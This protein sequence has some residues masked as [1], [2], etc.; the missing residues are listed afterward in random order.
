MPPVRKLSISGAQRKATLAVIFFTAVAMLAFAA[1]S[2][3]ARMALLTTTIDA[4]SFTTIR[5]V[6]GAVVL[7]AI[8]IAQ[9]QKMRVSGIGALSAFLLFVYAAAFSFAYRDISTG[10]G[11]LILF[12][13]VQ[14]VMI[15]WGLHKGERAHVPGLLLALGGLV[16]FLAPGVSAPPLFA[17]ALMAL[18]GIAWGGFSL[19]GK[20]GESPTAGTASSFVLAVPMALAMMLI[21]RNSLQL[22]PAGITLALLSGA[23]TSGL[24]YVIWYWVRVRLAAISA[25]AVQLSVPVISAILGVLI[26]NEEISLRSALAAVAVLAGIAL[27]TLSARRQPK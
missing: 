23:I 21:Q 14:L 1:N 24:G 18:S 5:I 17:S 9:R 26:L 12:A 7:Y 11:A 25:G 10:A 16:V 4:A 6:S 15:S 27:V 13:T 20:S 2:L 3:L 19:L 8:L 22:D